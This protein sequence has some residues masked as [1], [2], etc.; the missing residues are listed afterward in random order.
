MAMNLS[1]EYRIPAPPVRVWAALNDRD[2][3]KACIP[4]CKSLDKTSETSFASVVTSKVGPISATFTGSVTLSDLDPPRGY[5]ISGQGQGGAAGFAKMTARVTLSEVGTDTLLKYEANAEVGGK[6]ASVGSRLVQGVAKKNA[7][8][9]FAAIA[10]QL[11]GTGRP[12]SVEPTAEE[13]A[14]A[15]GGAKAGAPS[16]LL[17]AVA[18]VLVALIIYLVSR[19]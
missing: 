15:A 3:L 18:G 11:G 16:W 13:A 7:D 12:E 19:L 8:D 4:G 1:G 10:Q 6:L 5:T 14:R 2:V 17:W 9:F